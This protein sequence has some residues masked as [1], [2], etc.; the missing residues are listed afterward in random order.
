MQPFSEYTGLAEKNIDLR[1]FQF[2]KHTTDNK[3]LDNKG[4]SVLKF[5][6]FKM[7]FLTL[8]CNIAT[9]QLEINFTHSR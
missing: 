9:G 8:A 5:G 3:D 1:F 2:V 4:N 6:L 7:S